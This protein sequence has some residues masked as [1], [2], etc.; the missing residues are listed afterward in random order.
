MNG[1]KFETI[2]LAVLSLGRLSGL[3]CTEVKQ[4]KTS[5]KLRKNLLGSISVFS[6]SFCGMFWF[7]CLFV[8]CTFVL[9]TFWLIN[10]LSDVWRDLWFNF[11]FLVLATFVD[12]TDLTRQHI[13]FFIYVLFL[14]IFMHNILGANKHQRSHWW[15]ST[16]LQSHKYLIFFS[17]ID[18]QHSSGT[19][20]FNRIFFLIARLPAVYCHK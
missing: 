14:A 6:V 15:Q 9:A 20:L 13:R 11:H 19:K 18:G 1:C 5:L 4:D 2:W 12:F 8:C 3:M 16:S 17:F 7:V 10:V